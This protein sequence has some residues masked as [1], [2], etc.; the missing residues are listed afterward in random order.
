M[1]GRGAFGSVVKARDKFDSRIYAGMCLIFDNTFLYS[2]H[3]KVKKV[4]LKS[5][6]SDKILREVNALSR[7]SHRNIV[8][9]Y[10]TWVEMAEPDANVALPDK[11]SID[12][13]Y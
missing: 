8:R 7:L 4:R 6:Q 12:F 3:P 10:T 11:S 1:L 5:T 2:W 9:Y 13:F